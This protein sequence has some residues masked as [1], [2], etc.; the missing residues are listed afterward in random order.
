MSI[1]RVILIGLT[2]MAIALMGQDLLASLGQPQIQSRLQLYQTN[3]VLQASELQTDD[4]NLSAAQKNLLGQKPIQ[5]AI[6]AYQTVRQQAEENLAKA[7][8]LLQAEEKAAS[9]QTT[10]LN[11]SIATL[12]NLISDL[13]LDLGLLHQRQ[14]EAAAAQESWQ[15][16]TTAGSDRD[17][18]SPVAQAAQVLTGLWNEP[19]Q[20]LPNAEALINKNLEGWFRTQALIRLYQ[21]QQRQPNLDALLAQQ[22]QQAATAFTSLLLIVGIPGLSLVLGV[23]ILLTVLL[24]RLLQPK[25]AILSPEKFTAWTV[26]WDGEIVWQVLIFG[27]FLVGQIAIPFVFGGLRSAGLLNPLSDSERGKAILILLNYLLLAAGGLAVLY[28]SISPYKPLPEGWFNLKFNSR[29][30]LWGVGGYLAALPLVVGVSLVNQ[31]IWQ[32]QGGSNPI[33]PIALEGKDALSIGIFFF[34]AAIAAPVFEEILFRGFLLPSLTRYVPMWWAIATSSLLFAVAHLSLSEVLPLT[35]LGMMLAFVYAR[36]GSLL[37]S[38]LL[39]SL[40]NAGTLLSLIILG[41]ASR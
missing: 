27:F 19:P 18:L 15:T 21:L 41:Q 1:K 26:P 24:Q 17:G 22:Q 13:A 8:T 11:Q 7:N 4:P 40:W 39:H 10:S 3:L 5:A 9:A 25:Q 20:L 30:L 23:G 16:A 38:M 33:L 12:S 36:S 34:T 37:S 31:R 6:E 35:V 29:W 14:G 32:G 28:G 2:L